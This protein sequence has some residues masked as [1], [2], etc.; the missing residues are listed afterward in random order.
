MD[1]VS[2]VIATRDRREELAR[3]VS[4]LSDLPERPPIIVVDNASGEPVGRLPGARVIRLDRN[5]GAAARNVGV[6]AAETPY[7]AFSDDDSWWMPGALS[8]AAEAFA[9]YP[10]LGLI[11]ARTL[12][13]P[14]LAPDPINAAM[15]ATPLPGG[16][17]LAGPPV[18][19]FLACAAIVRREAFTAVGG[20]SNLLFFVGEERLL[21]YDLAAAGWDR[22]YLP[23]VVA[24]H[25]PSR[26]RPPAAHRRRSEL[27]NTVLTQWLRRPVPLALRSSGRLATAA[28]RDADARH[29]LA[30][31]ARRLPA[32]LAAR[33]PLPDSVERAVRL[34]EAAS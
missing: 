15:A 26:R 1:A 10:G 22:C 33:D 11:A 17:Q 12:V 34:L 8:R 16:S 30:G 21:A 20:F 19:G 2:V 13:G 23:E 14:D 28:L 29:A 5:A 32:A 6:A 18:L 3:T 7:V 4:R 27:R 9:A 31:A 25:H 24:V